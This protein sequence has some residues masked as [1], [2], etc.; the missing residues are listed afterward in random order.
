MF[1]CA[2]VSKLCIARTAR[3]RALSAD[4]EESCISIG[5]A[6]QQF[7]RVGR[8]PG[9]DRRSFG[10]HGDDGDKYHGNGVGASY[11]PPFGAGDTVGC[12]IDYRSQ[13]VFFTKNGSFLGM[14]ASRCATRQCIL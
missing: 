6:T 3:G 9:W 1:V 12:G 11:G 4:S 7:P 5:V 14:C 13:S 8:Q 2:L 10:Y